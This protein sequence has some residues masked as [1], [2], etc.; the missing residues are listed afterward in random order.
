[1][2]WQGVAFLRSLHHDDRTD[3]LGGRSDVEVQRFTILGRREDRRVGERRLEFVKHLLSLDGPG[4][5]LVL[6]QEL[7]KRQAL[8]TEPRDEAAQGGKAPQHILHPFEVSN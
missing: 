2:D 1:L 8:L 6:L 7:V 4:E 3:H 5:G